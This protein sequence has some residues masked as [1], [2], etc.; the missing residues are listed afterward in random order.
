LTDFTTLADVKA[1]L[2]TGTDPFPPRDDAML[3]RLITSCSTFIE[4]WL[5]RPL[6]L[7]N[8]QEIRD[9]WG[10]ERAYRMPLAVSP[11]VGI[12]SLTID[13]LAIPPA[14]VLNAQT[15]TFGSVAGYTFTPTELGLRGYRFTRGMQNVTVQYTAGYEDIPA[16][17][18][19]A[20]LEMVVR[21]YRERT[22]IAE[23]SRSLGGGET[24]A[25]ST[26]MFSRRDMGTD[27]QVLLQQYRQS[28]LLLRPTLLPPLPLG[29]QL[30]DVVTV[31]ELEDATTPI[32]SEP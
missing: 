25:Y 23:R 13:G 14:P 11:V 28:A 26:V 22:R 9:G 1:W 10:G 19:Q 2:Q 6:G 3:A 5:S 12:I 17:V 7:A 32:A 29:L 8:W 30:E 20:C 27:I 16:D 21:K 31:I 4:S 18:Q 24:V 15:T